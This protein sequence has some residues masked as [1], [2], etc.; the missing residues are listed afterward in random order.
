MTGE[1]VLRWLAEQKTV[2]VVRRHTGEGLVIALHN[3]PEIKWNER[4]GETE[5]PEW[6][7]VTYRLE[8]DDKMG[9]Q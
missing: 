5:G 4:T 1:D 7:E 6:Q 8:S 9:Q 3:G 2:S